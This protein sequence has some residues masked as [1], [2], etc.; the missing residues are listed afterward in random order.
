ML[1]NDYKELYINS[2]KVL[3][4]YLNGVELFGSKPITPSLSWTE[5]QA[6]VQNGTIAESVPIGTKFTIDCGDYGVI[7]WVAVNHTYKGL[8]TLVLMPTVVLSES[9]KYQSKTDKIRAYSGSLVN[10]KCNSVVNNLPVE[11]QNVL[12]T[13]SVNAMYSATSVSSYTVKCAIPSL[14]EIT[15]KTDGYN[16]LGTDI[17]TFFQNTNFSYA[18]LIWTRTR[19]DFNAYRMYTCASYN[20]TVGSSAATG[21]TSAFVPMIFIG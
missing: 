17:F 6:S 20:G 10:S 15:G 8:N 21:E 7:D 1:L 12:V 18:T 4:A 5:I 2:K 9:M 19:T 13:R 14:Y 11:I 16:K 3:S